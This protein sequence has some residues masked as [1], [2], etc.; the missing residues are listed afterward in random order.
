MNTMTEVLKNPSA[1]ASYNVFST[2]HPLYE[3]YFECRQA[4]LAA[5]EAS[6]E[7]WEKAYNEAFMEQ[8]KK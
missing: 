4:G 6:G 2:E 3:C 7:G 8:Y 1:H 5:A